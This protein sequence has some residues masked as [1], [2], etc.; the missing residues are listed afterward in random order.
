MAVVRVKERRWKIF[1]RH[2]VHEG[3]PEILERTENGLK[4]RVGGAT[5][6]LV[7]EGKRYAVTVLLGEKAY[8]GAGTGHAHEH[9][10]VTGLPKK[11]IYRLAFGELPEDV[12]SVKRALRV[13]RRLVLHAEKV[14]VELTAPD[15]LKILEHLS[16]RE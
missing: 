1:P 9:P 3:E 7:R 2:I 10:P 13:Y 8:G 14:T 5:L 15:L 11:E 4:M 16:R 12:E 6:H